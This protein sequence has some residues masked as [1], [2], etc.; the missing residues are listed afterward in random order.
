M[1]TT[2][3]TRLPIARIDALD[4]LLGRAPAPPPPAPPPCAA[5]PEEPADPGEV[6]RD[7]VLAPYPPRRD[8][9]GG[10]RAVNL[11]VESFAL[12]GVEAPGVALVDRVRAQLGPGRTVWGARHDRER[13]PAWELYVYDPGRERAEASLDAVLAAI[14]DLVA[15][16]DRLDRP[17]A[18]HMWSLA[19]DAATL[20]TGRGGRLT[21]YVN[22]SDLPG[23]SRS[24]TI[25]PTGPTLA[26]LYT[27]HDPRRDPRAILD[28]LRSSVHLGAPPEGVAA[29]LWPGL[30]RCRRLCVANKPAADGLYFS[31]I[32]TDQLAYVL[33]RTGW[34]A[35]LRAY[36][37]GRRARFAHL[38]WDVGLDFTRGDAP[39]A[40]PVIARSAVYATC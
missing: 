6:L 37:D 40:P 4:A 25:G 10:L 19:F 24:Y 16:P 14:A 38:A 26:N 11:L 28:R 1:S 9:T 31:G 7:Y 12:A 22:G 21:V 2:P 20:A 5:R 23:A 15:V 29:V 17:I 30:Q 13:G 32:D 8:P 33:A 36:L 34:P 3:R 18:H 27:F 39:D 35:P